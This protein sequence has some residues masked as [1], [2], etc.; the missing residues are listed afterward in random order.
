MRRLALVGRLGWLCRLGLLGV[1]GLGLALLAPA[2][3]SAAPAPL[4]DVFVV[5]RTDVL[6]ES[7]EVRARAASVK[8]AGKTCR[9]AD[10]TPLAALKALRLRGGPAYSLRDY[11]SCSRRVADAGGLFVTKLGRDRNQGRDGWVYKVGRKVG[12]TSA[13]DASGPFGSG[14]LRAGDAVTWFWCVSQSAGGCQRTLEVKSARTVGPGASL[15]VTVR[16]FDD[17]GGGRPIAGASV[18]FAGTTSL[19]GDDGKATVTAPP[20]GGLYTVTAAKSGMVRS[21]PLEVAVR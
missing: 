16:G 13:G 8:I 21:R 1:A 9:V 15:S 18:S 5:G 12:S 3:A 17:Q 10:G 20:A 11:G 14:R 19:T 7:T 4:V 2:G 6:R